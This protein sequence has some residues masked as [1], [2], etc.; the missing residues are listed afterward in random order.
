[1]YTGPSTLAFPG[2][3]TS[4][5]APLRRH[6]TDAVSKHAKAPDGDTFPHPRIP[7]RSMTSLDAAS[8]GA[9]TSNNGHG[10]LSGPGSSMF[11]ERG[12]SSMSRPRADSSHANAHNVLT[13]SDSARK[14][15]TSLHSSAARP[16]PPVPLPPLPTFNQGNTAS[17]DN[18]SASAT[19]AGSQ[20][21]IMQQRIFIGDMQRFS[22]VDLGARTNA[23]DVLRAIESKGDLGAQ[24]VEG[25]DWMMFEVANDFGMGQC[26]SLFSFTFDIVWLRPMRLTKT[27]YWSCRTSC[28]GVRNCIGNLQLVEL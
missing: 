8:H 21:I 23:R 19:D 16:A 20:D 3:N 10:I 9:E 1:V 28:P 2:S 7:E 14:R 13:A 12:R 15:A 22:V 4:S 17:F 27:D 11:L 5:S 24:E 18:G 25:G 26:N 6:A